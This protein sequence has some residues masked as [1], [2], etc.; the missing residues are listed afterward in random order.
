MGKYG[1][2]FKDTDP[3]TGSIS[4]T[5]SIATVSATENSLNWI[6]EAL[7]NYDDDPNRD[8]YYL[9]IPRKDQKIECQQIE[10]LNS[11]GP[12]LIAQKRGDGEFTI[13]DKHRKS[14]AVLSESEI[15]DFVH[16]NMVIGDS[17]GDTW[18]YAELP[19]SMKP[20]LKKLDEFIGIDTTGKSY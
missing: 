4:Q 16:G 7:Y 3:D 1:L 19:G 17:Q 2:Y 15:Y 9:E 12:I 5:N 18:R 10:L 14:I 6:K 11:E 20:D 8:F 13:I